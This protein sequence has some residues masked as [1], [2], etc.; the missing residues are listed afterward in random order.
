MLVLT[1]KVGEQI[2]IG[3]DI[4]VTVLDMTKG[5]VRLGI[6]APRQVSIHRHEVYERI[7]EENLRASQGAISEIE[8]MANIWREKQ[9]KE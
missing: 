6:E 1:R 4:L 2:R 3:E 8:N 9:D 5:N 7:L